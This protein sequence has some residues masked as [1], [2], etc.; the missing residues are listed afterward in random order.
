MDQLKWNCVMSHVGYFGG[1]EEEDKPRGDSDRFQSLLIA[2]AR[3]VGD[4]TK[5]DD[6]AILRSPASSGSPH[7]FVRVQTITIAGA[8]MRP[9]C[10]VGQAPHAWYPSF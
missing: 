8:G 9:F 7:C 3:V 10:R 5:Q 2:Q 4:T 6:A 1:K